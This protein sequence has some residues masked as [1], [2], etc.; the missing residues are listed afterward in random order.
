MGQSKLALW[1]S[2]AIG[3][4]TLILRLFFARATDVQ[5]ACVADVGGLTA[6][7]HALP[8]DVVRASMLLASLLSV[9][10]AFE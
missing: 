5:S 9:A 10:Y 6:A 3:K 8:D 4:L 1:S 7:E 2:C